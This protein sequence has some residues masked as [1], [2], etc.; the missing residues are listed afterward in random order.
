MENDAASVPPSVYVSTSGTGSLAVT[1][2]HCVVRGV[3]S[4]LAVIGMPEGR[5]VSPPPA[6]G[7]FC[8]DQRSA[9]GPSA[10][11]ILVSESWSLGTR[12]KALLSVSAYG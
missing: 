3:S 8:V 10:G 6:F 12:G 1:G 9:P 2:C 5:R 11:N 4:G 7:A